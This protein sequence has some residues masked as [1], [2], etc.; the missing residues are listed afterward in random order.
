MN[1]HYII[2]GFE[3]L[4]DYLNGTIF[5]WASGARAT[6]FL[7]DK[8]NELGYENFNGHR[9]L[10]IN[11]K[12]LFG[13]MLHID[14]EARIINENEQKLADEFRKFVKIELRMDIETDI[15]CFESHISHLVDPSYLLSKN[16][17]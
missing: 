5:E 16:L 11:E 9:L 2:V 13:I 3:I 17:K 15:F 4:E 7:F 6:H 14:H 10:A 1:W 12:N 8:V